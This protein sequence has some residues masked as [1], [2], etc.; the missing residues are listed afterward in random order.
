M[1]SITL[2]SPANAPAVIRYEAFVKPR[3]RN[4]TE[5]GASILISF[6]GTIP[7]R[8]AATRMYK[9]VHT[10]NDAMMPIGRSRCGFLASC[11][12]VETASNPIYAKK[13][14]AAPA[15][16]PPKPIGANVDQSCPQFRSEE[17]TSELQSP[18]DLVCRL[19][20]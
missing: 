1:T 15:P 20:L 19:L 12:V 9:I 3:S 13:I 7:V 5:S 11:A 4:A 16:I 18:Y 8:T 2:V 14:Y 17:H 10:T 6:Q